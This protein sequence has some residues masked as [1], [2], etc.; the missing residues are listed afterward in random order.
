MYIEA[1]MLS[2]DPKGLGTF[3]E[4][5][6]VSRRREESVLLQGVDTTRYGHDAKYETD[7][8]MSATWS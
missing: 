6:G 8:A 7:T 1:V 2:L 3:V 4:T 5:V